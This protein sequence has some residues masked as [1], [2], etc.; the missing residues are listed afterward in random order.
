MSTYVVSLEWFMGE[1]TERTDIEADDLDDAAR[2]AYEHWSKT[3]WTAAGLSENGRHIS[4]DLEANTFEEAIW[5]SG[6]D[7][8]GV[9]VTGKEEQGNG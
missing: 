8:I 2:K 6:K 5:D 7:S 3:G 4:L 1:D 9:P